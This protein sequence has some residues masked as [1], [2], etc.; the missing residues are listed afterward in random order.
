[1]A[2][3]QHTHAT[4]A[5]GGPIA[6]M[7]G[8]FEIYSSQTGINPETTYQTWV[9]VSEDRTAFWLNGSHIPAGVTAQLVVWTYPA[10]KALSFR[11]YN[12][13]AAAA[14]VGSTAVSSGG[15]AWEEAVSGDCRAG[16]ASGLNRYHIQ[17]YNATSGGDDGT[18]ISA[19]L[20]IQ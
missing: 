9:D 8:S 12:E 5:L 18:F 19:A 2:N 7:S 17:V 20:L 15:S 16:F 4:A 13:T 3:A 1:M 10:G 6:I 14:V 11:I